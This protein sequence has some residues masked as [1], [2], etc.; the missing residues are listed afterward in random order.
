MVSA[1]MKD[2]GP[3]ES[4]IS[5]EYP[6][7][8]LGDLKRMFPFDDNGGICHLAEQGSSHL[9]LRLSEELVD[10]IEGEAIAQIDNGQFAMAKEI[11]SRNRKLKK[12]YGAVRDIVDKA[13]RG[14]DV[15]ATA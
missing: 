15:A 8:I 1:N 5:V 4:E 6:P 14:T 10:D 13:S 12:L 7:W 2:L 11:L 3:I 9:L